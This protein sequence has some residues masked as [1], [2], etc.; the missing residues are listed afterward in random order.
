MS[1]KQ[2]SKSTTSTGSSATPFWIESPEVLVAPAHITEIWPMS[3]MDFVAKL[4]AMTRLVIVL[5]IIGGLITRGIRIL[6]VGAVTI[7]VLVF[8]YYSEKYSGAPSASKEGFQSMSKKLGGHGAAPG[9]FYKAAP[10][11]PMGNVLLP[12]IGDD[13]QR[14]MAA[15][16]FND[17]VQASINE[18]TKQ[19]IQ[20]LNPSIPDLDEKLFKDLGDNFDFEN[21]MIN[22]YST[23][24][25]QVPND[26][27]AFAQF[28]YGNMGSCKDV[29]TPQYCAGDPPRIGAV[30]N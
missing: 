6:V 25:T 7:G 30:V 15:P 12:E 13:P 2:H 28:C 19:M 23:A 29:S 24:N 18:K 14:K 16:A 10:A 5:T 20:D 3:S 27:K 17:T 21:S 4:N 22:F 11:N 26:Q 8:L 1:Q 9:G